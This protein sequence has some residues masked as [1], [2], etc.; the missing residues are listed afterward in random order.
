MPTN[1]CIFKNEG[2]IEKL[3]ANR[4]RIK[5]ILGQDSYHIDDK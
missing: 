2:T 5:E 3:K 1:F 4:F